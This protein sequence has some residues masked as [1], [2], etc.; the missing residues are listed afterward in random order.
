MRSLT[1]CLLSILLSS[2]SAA[3][4]PV[5][6]PAFV[7]ANQWSS[8]R[9]QSRLNGENEYYRF[10]QASDERFGQILR[11]EFKIREPKQ[12]YND[13]S[14][15]FPIATPWDEVRLWVRNGGSKATTFFLK[16]VDSD[17]AEYAPRPLG[18]TIPGDGGWHRVSFRYS[19]FDMAP[20]YRGRAA[21]LDLPVKS[22]G[23]VFYDVKAG[24]EHRFDFAGCELLR[25]PPRDIRVERIDAPTGLSAG[26]ELRLGLTLSAGEALDDQPLVLSLIRNGQLARKWRVAFPKPLPQWH[27]DERI[28]VPIEPLHFPRYAEGGRCELHARVGWTNLHGTDG[29]DA[30]ARFEVTARKPGPFPEAEV[31]PHHGVPTLWINGEPDAAMT[32]MSYDQRQTRWFGDFGKAGVNLATFSATSDFMPY[33]YAPPTWLAP[34]VFDYGRFDE[35]IAAILEANPQAWVFPRVYLAAP[36]WWCEKFPGEVAREAD[37]RSPAEALRRSKPFASIASAKWQQDT[38]ESLRR[39]IAHVRSA[40]YA[41]RVIG[42]HLASLHTEEW[43]WHDFWENSPGYWGYDEPSRQAFRRFLRRRY[44]DVEALRTAWRDPTID[45]ESA[46]VPPKELR[47]G[48]DLGFFRDPV[49]SQRVADFYRYHNEI[50][51]ETIETFARVVKQATGPKQLCGVFYGYLF[52]LAGSP[53]SGHLALGRLLECPDVDFLCAPSCYEFRPIGS[54]ASAFM[55]VTESIRLHGK[56]WFN[57][58]DYRTHRAQDAPAYRVPM[59]NLADTIE[60]EKRE[61][62]HVIT[63]GTGMWWFDM[64]GGWFD[65]PAVMQSI[66]R[67]NAVA[68]RSIAFDRSSAAEI[69]VVVD[70]ESMDYRESR[71]RLAEDL[72]NA[73][74]LALQRMGAPFDC[75]L[76]TD[77]PRLRPYKLYIFLNT[78]RIT[79]LQRKMIE[80]VIRRDGRT[81]L[82]VY[83]PGFVGQTL[84][85]EGIS[86]LTGMKIGRS[87]APQRLRVRLLP[88][89]DPIVQELPAEPVWGGLYPVQPAFFCDDAQAL[90]LGRIEGLGKP[91]LTVRR[92]GQ[93]TSIWSAAPNLPAWLL[94]SIA[95]SAG[96]HITS[97]A[98]DALYLNRS[99]LAL[100]TNQPGPRRLRFAKPTSLYDVYGQRPVARDVTAVTLDLPGKHTAIYFLGTEE[101]WVR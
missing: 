32:F 82:W 100:H 90:V 73:Q 34:D 38:A 5:P 95:R 15:L 64:D 80:S 60:I 14:G 23:L 47:A 63:Q 18:V 83:G 3:E 17:D 61:L 56:L 85:E 20:W 41:N 50:V 11:W 68:Q 31:R 12:E 48:A 40:P 1:A 27:P 39:F 33:N 45:F 96:V 94:R 46:D 92:F 88:G 74:R 36:P 49:R 6:V 99:F 97:D 13:L 67:M 35:R 65:E 9:E 10:T 43:F 22:V 28:A 101:Q 58:N 72:L 93:W 26:E 76:L 87:D 98:D 44:P 24:E 84:S 21:P 66:A 71:G 4:S 7:D 55:S 52:E 53:E 78:I 30:L 51:A 91:G 59:T 29:T 86:A 37:Q 42:Y 79:P 81:A 2:A 89:E 57:E 25:P 70:E 62:A 8:L 75:V 54:G 77:L 69:A 19:Q 16:L